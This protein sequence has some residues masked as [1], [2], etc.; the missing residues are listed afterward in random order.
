MSNPNDLQASVE[1]Q[2]EESFE[3][4]AKFKDKSTEDVVKMYTDL[5]R[6]RS[7][8]ANEVGT[9]R[10]MA[11]QLLGLQQ[12]R[13]QATTRVERKPVTTDDLLQNPEEALERAI[14]DNPEISATKQELSRLRAQMAQTSFEREYPTWQD[15]LSNPE[16]VDWIKGNKVR[17]ALGI[18]SN[19]GDYDAAASLWGLWQ[20]RQAES[21][22]IKSKKKELA[23][24]AEKLGT[25]EGSGTTGLESD[26][27]YSRV[28]MME[29]NRKAL[30]G[31]PEAK[32][33]WND[34]T[35]QAERL[36]AYAEKRVK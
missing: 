14:Q 35:F 22:T 33:K 30:A 25:L 4:P 23:K 19:N 29:L 1:D 18:A 10:Q 21:A 27:I 9:L 24:K 2:L 17:T 36:K 5:E 8:L 26:K 6:D 15:D 12:E 20:E 3:L 31:D 11:D 34:P 16:F 32:A 28:D 7:R 13:G